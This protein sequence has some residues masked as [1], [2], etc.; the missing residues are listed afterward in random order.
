MVQDGNDFSGTTGL[1]WDVTTWEDADGND[2]EADLVLN[3]EADLTGT[4]SDENIKQAIAALTGTCDGDECEDY[5]G[6]NGVEENPC[7]A[8]LVGELV[9]Q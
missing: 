4:F 1:T 3:M 2:V 5:M 7:S 6:V 8:T 9:A